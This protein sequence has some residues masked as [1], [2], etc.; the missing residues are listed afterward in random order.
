MRKLIV[1]VF[2]VAVAT[3]SCDGPAA[4]KKSEAT[5]EE[6]KQ[7]QVEQAAQQEATRLAEQT[8]EL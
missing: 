6:Q 7:R 3:V 5:Q 8:A 1:L 2:S 4:T